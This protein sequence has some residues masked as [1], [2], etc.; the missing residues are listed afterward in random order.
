M[1]RARI[2]LDDSAPRATA[3]RAVSGRD[4]PA[5]PDARALRNAL[6]HFATGVTVVTAETPSGRRAGLTA[7]SFV[8]VSLDPPLISVCIASKSRGT[9]VIRD[10]GAFA[11]HVLHAEQEGLARIFARPGPDKLAH[12]GLERSAL[13]NPVLERWLVLLECDL[14]AE[15]PG[16]DHRIFLGRVRRLRTHRRGGSALTFFRGRFASLGTE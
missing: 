6:G 8:S 11:V 1:E 2:P 14:H 16:G 3:L 15:Y 7:N 10:A 4:V 12:L 5:T 13:G 9:S